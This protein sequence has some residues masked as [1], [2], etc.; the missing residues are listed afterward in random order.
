MELAGKPGGPWLGRLQKHLLD[1]VL[2]DPGQNTGTA[3]QR[4]AASWLKAEG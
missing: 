4:L 3:L 2:E 1:A